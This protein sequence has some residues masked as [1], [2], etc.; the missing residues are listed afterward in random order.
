VWPQSETTSVSQTEREN[1]PMTAPTLAP[2]PT[3]NPPAVGRPASHHVAAVA[4]VLAAVW[5]RS[6]GTFWTLE[7]HQLDSGAAP[8]TIVDWISSGVPITQ[9]E[10]P[11]ALDR[12]LLAER[13]LHL[14]HD[15]SAGPGTHNRRG[16]GYVCPDAELITL[17]HL[18]RDDATEA[19]VHPV[20]LAAQ[21]IAA[22]VS[23]ARWIRQ[24]VH[25]PQAALHQAMS[26]EFTVPATQT[27]TS[28]RPPSRLRNRTCGL[29]GTAASRGRRCPCRR[30]R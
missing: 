25:P 24:R 22:G 14:F 10:P 29:R 8:G 19:G 30:G 13:G 3:Q 11:K 26:F 6:V 5:C 23:A 1:H 12:E 9:P 21:W 4:P 18:V 27:N 17:A 16:I 28:S 20:V 15:P 2:P 7:L